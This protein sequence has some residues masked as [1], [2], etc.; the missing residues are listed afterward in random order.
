M[1]VISALVVSFTLWLLLQMVGTA[2]AL[3]ETG[4]SPLAHASS[5]EVVV[6]A[7][8]QETVYLINDTGTTIVLSGAVINAVDIATNPP[9]F[10]VVL[11][12]QP[13][14]SAPDN[15]LSRLGFPIAAAQ[16]LALTI[17]ADEAA[18][19]EA[20]AEL[21]L[22]IAP[23][24]EESS[25]SV[26]QIALRTTKSAQLVAPGVDKWTITDLRR[27]PFW[28]GGRYLDVNVPLTQ[29]SPCTGQSLPSAI[30]SSED[31][32][33]YVTA[34]CQVVDG[35]PSAVLSVSGDSDR[36]STYT[37]TLRLLGEDD[38]GDVIL[39]LH[40]RDDWPGPLLFLMLGVGLSLFVKRQLDVNGVIGDRLDR[41]KDIEGSG[42][43]SPGPPEYGIRDYVLPEITRLRNALRSVRKKHWFSLPDDDA[44]LLASDKTIAELEVLTETFR[45]SSRAVEQVREATRSFKPRRPRPNLPPL[46]AKAKLLELMPAII[47]MD[48]AKLAQV[49]TALTAQRDFLFDNWKEFSEDITA[50]RTW[51]EIV[52]KADN[53]NSLTKEVEKC[54][55]DLDQL[56][57]RWWSVDDPAAAEAAKPQEKLD[58]IIAAIATLV[59]RLPDEKVR[60]LRHLS[61]ARNRRRV[62][63]NGPR[64]VG[65]TT[66]LLAEAY[67]TEGIRAAVGYQR[68]PVRSFVGRYNRTAARWLTILIAAPT[69]AW[70][71]MLAIWVGKDFGSLTDYI[72]ITAWG[73]TITPVLAVF[74]TALERLRPALTE[75]PNVRT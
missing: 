42:L 33:A 73:L 9:P 46:R 12:G 66:N 13:G 67:A 31:D 69:V 54:E 27:F 6:A 34:T 5:E 1:R 28:A 58:V 26:V 21:T 24:G 38:A 20:E 55:S 36:G 48:A 68:A 59:A 71:G 70:A 60:I 44:Q 16:R 72:T 64:Y 74:I 56:A 61:D 17:S 22:A 23:L 51:L 18:S 25:G 4:P 53:S 47:D 45:S 52:R 50:Q 75:A 62:T 30:L 57:I 2:A 65:L 40:R 29:D 49:E 11:A 41:L 39:T 10:S 7:G 8:M 15:D 19:A 14:G 32:A 43:T 35:R 3:D 37:G 63:G